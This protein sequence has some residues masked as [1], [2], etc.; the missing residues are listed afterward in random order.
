ML[1]V[2]VNYGENTDKSNLYMSL[3]GTNFADLN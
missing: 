1:Y 2:Y 3:T